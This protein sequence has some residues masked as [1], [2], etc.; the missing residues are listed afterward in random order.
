MPVIGVI[1]PFRKVTL[2]S[3]QIMSYKMGHD[4]KRMLLKWSWSH[5]MYVK[6]NCSLLVTS[7]EDLCKCLFKYRSGQYS[8]NEI[9]VLSY[10][11]RKAGA[12][13]EWG[14]LIR[15]L[16]KISTAL[17]KL[18]NVKIKAKLFL[19]T[20]WSHI[21]EWRYSSIYSYPHRYMEVVG[22]HHA[23]AALTL[24]DW[25][26]SRGYLKVFG[27]QKNIFPRPA[28]EPRTSSP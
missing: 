10:K 26:G 5:K 28:F 24:V 13:D 16:I 17:I 12:A 1:L 2:N 9:V 19:S 23:T 22:Q 21:G 6:C 25:V 3:L 18:W 15:N 27:E 14:P 4:S 7:P 20:P 8:N 11:L